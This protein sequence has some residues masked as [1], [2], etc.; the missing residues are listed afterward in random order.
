MLSAWPGTLLSLLLFGETFLGGALAN[1]LAGRVGVLDIYI[2]NYLTAVQYCSTT[3]TVLLH[4]LRRLSFCPASSNPAWRHG[5]VVSSILRAVYSWAA[6][7]GF[8]HIPPTFAGR[9]RKAHRQQLYPLRDFSFQILHHR[10]RS[11]GLHHL[12]FSP[13]C[14]SC[15]SGGEG[16]RP[17][18]SNLMRETTPTPRNF[19]ARLAATPLQLVKAANLHE[20]VAALDPC[21]LPSSHHHITYPPDH[22]STTLDMTLWNLYNTLHLASG[23]RPPSCRLPF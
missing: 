23:N 12:I 5:L 6:F 21:P 16:P 8:P 4:L 19:R 18:S 7:F 17:V 3:T 14:P 15:L 9:G 2:T 11:P 13:D 10:S 1:V 22:T 20:C